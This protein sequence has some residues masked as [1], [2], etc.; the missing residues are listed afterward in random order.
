MQLLGVVIHLTLHLPNDHG[1]EEQT[2]RQQLL[3]DLSVKKTLLAHL[4]VKIVLPGSEGSCQGLPRINR[5]NNRL[6]TVGRQPGAAGFHQSWIAQHE[7]NSE[8]R[9]GHPGIRSV[10]VSES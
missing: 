7:S 3:L 5:Q 2:R 1:G 8:G 10:E 9:P 4:S 6:V